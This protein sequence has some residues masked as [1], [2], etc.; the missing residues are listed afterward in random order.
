MVRAQGLDWATRFT[1]VMGL[2]VVQ[3]FEGPHSARSSAW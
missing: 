2:I 1:S 3:I